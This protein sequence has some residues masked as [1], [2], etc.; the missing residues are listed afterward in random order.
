MPVE[1]DA[2][3][4]APSGAPLFFC[5][6]LQPLHPIRQGLPLEGLQAR[7]NEAPLGREGGADDLDFTGEERIFQ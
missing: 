5:I 1:F 7:H 6:C 3:T 2:F 4:G